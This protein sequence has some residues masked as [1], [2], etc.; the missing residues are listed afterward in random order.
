MRA[1]PLGVPTLVFDDLVL[2][3]DTGQA[4]TKTWDLPA[5]WRWSYGNANLASFVYEWSLC[6]PNAPATAPNIALFVMRS[7]DRL[8][9][10]EVFEPMNGPAG[11]VITSNS[12]SQREDFGRKATASTYL[13]PTGIGA[14][15]VTNGSASTAVIIRLRVWVTLQRYT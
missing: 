10:A 12:G 4:N 5:H 2:T 6:Q 1:I 9:D 3:D 15:R 11:L 7:T 14:L 8:I 13:A